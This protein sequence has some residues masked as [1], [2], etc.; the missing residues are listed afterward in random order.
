MK[1]KFL[2][3][4]L[5]IVVLLSSWKQSQSETSTNS[6]AGKIKISIMYPNELGKSFDM[7]YYAQN[8]MPMVSELFGEALLDYGI[9]KG[10]SG[11]TP[12]EPM[13][14][15]AIGYFYFNSIEEYGKAFGANA[16][17]ILGDIPNYTNI[18]P[19]VQISEVVR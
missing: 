17:K 19:T 2:I 5:G 7:D 1:T 8:H 16:E 6:E 13:S 18:E 10:I 9:E 12:E 3:L 4:F 15:V 14:Y 11:R